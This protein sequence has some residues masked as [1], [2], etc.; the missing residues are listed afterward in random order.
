MVGTNMHR[1]FEDSQVTV[2][3]RQSG[4]FRVVQ[5]PIRRIEVTVLPR[6]REFTIWLKT[7]RPMHVSEEVVSR[8]YR[9]HARLR[10]AKRYEGIVFSG[11]SPTLADGYDVG[12]RLLLA[13]SAAESMGGAVG[14]K[15]TSW[16]LHNWEIVRPLRRIAGELVDLPVGLG[17]KMNTKLIEFV[18]EQTDNIRIPATALRHLMAHG[19]FA[20]AGKIGL[21]KAD[22]A[23]VRQL[24]DDLIAE[25]ERQFGRWLDRVLLPATE[26]SS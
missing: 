1:G 4:A 10:V 16:E 22:R 7:E 25:T 2:A 3:S 24:A 13:Y 12:V 11:V 18:G 5:L 6:F 9:A 17:K 26:H 8:M 23:A 14:V 21:K 15:V 19:H 20:P